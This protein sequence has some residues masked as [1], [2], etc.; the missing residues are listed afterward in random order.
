MAIPDLLLDLEF[1]IPNIVPS[2]LVEQLQVPEL[3]Y[4]FSLHCSHLSHLLFSFFC[5]VPA[6]IEE[7]C[8]LKLRM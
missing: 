3:H 2:F 4:L 7:F 6:D 5:F 8:D 1:Y